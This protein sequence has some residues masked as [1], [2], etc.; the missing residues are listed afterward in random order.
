MKVNYSSIF[1]TLFVLSFLACGNGTGSQQTLVDSLQEALDHRNEEYRQLDEYLTI[2]SSSLDSISKQES[3]IFNVNQESPAPNREKIKKDLETF[4]QNLKIQRERIS[5]LEQQLKTQKDGNQKL[6]AII[7][8]LKTQLAEKE[9]QIANLRN[10]VSKKD[11]N[12]DEL[13]KN[14]SEMMYVNKRQRDLIGS[15]REMIASQDE[16]INQG[17]IK[18]GSKSELKESGVLTGGFLKKSKVDYSQVDKSKFFAVDIRKFTEL[19]INS[20]NPKILTNVPEESYIL[21]RNGD[22]TKLR[23]I[24]PERFWSVSKYLIIQI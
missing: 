19:D 13:Y 23:I 15:Q 17:F 24:D 11:A 3:D 16:L 4:Q 7:N 2:I 8:S 22:K 9:T 6:Q 10:E 18:I 21:D 1:S 12:I 20:K 5:K 14:L